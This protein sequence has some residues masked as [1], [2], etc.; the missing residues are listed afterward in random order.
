MSRFAPLDPGLNRMPEAVRRVHLMGVC[1]TAMGALAAMLAEMGME[2]RGSDSGVY[3]PMSDYL[4]ARRIPVSE[5]FRPE[6]LAWRPDLVVV[7]NVIRRDNPEIAA[8]ARAA[9]PYLSMPQALAGFFIKDARSLVV[10]GTHG[11]TTTAA[12]LASALFSAGFDPGFVIGGIL[13]GFDANFRIGSGRICVLEGDEYDTAFFDKGP[14]F[15]HYRP[16]IAILTSVE[17][18]HADIF[19]DFGAVKKTFARLPAVLPDDG[20]LVVNGDDPEAVR[21]AAL[22]RCRVE[23]YGTGKG[24]GWRMVDPVADGEG[25]SFLLRGPD[26]E[27]RLRL[28]MSG[29]HNCM[30]AAA[31]AVALINAG[32]AEEDAAAGIAGFAGVRRRQEV[33]GE[34]F[35]VT[36]IDDFAHHPTA[37]AV[38]LE[39]LRNRYRGRRLIAVFEA[40]SNTSRRRV[41]QERFAQAFA[42]ADAVFVREPEPLLGVEADE[43]FSASRLVDDLAR[44][45]IR[46]ELGPDPEAI[47][48]RLEEFLM[49]GDVVAVL[50]NG[51]F[52]NIH[53]RLLAMLR[54]REKQAGG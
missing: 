41:F 15:P 47:V 7:G 4:A 23:S 26:C 33:R 40:R 2:V 9:V 25:M 30:N 12:M 44:Q 5:G 36:V 54:G 51:G 8:L 50:S 35:G 39:G 29:L 13:K 22:A 24:C 20:L 27:L 42:A 48:V 6:N 21:I 28:P 43:L 3:P 45:G 11:K 19:A 17:F 34:A 46:A 37:V 49:P 38:T 1:G 16:G 53:E 10:C 18:D 52:G 31:A 14:K 32:V